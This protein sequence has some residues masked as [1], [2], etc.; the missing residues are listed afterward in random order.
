MNAKTLGLVLALCGIAI[1]VYNV[2]DP[3]WR[4]NVDPWPRV[5]LAVGAVLIAG[6]LFAYFKSPKRSN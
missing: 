6:G 2:F 5:G 4:F 3:T 1:F